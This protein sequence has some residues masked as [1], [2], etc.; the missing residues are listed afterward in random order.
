MIHPRC[1]PRPASVVVIGPY[2]VHNF[3]D[4]LIGAVL[5]SHLNRQCG[6]EILIPGLSESNRRW[7]GTSSESSWVRAF[8]R[9]SH[10]LIG[11]GGI[12]GDS[13]LAPS[14]RYLKRSA[15]AA[16][17]GQ[18]TGR[19][20]CICGVGAG[21]LVRTSSRFLCRLTCAL[22]SRI[23]VRD[24]ESEAFL[25]H[26]LGVPQ[27]KIQVGADLALCWPE[28]L[29]V[30]PSSSDRIGI[31][32]DVEHYVSITPGSP[33]DASIQRVR[34]FCRNRGD[35]MLS[36]SNVSYDTNTA[37]D[38]A[39]LPWKTLFYAELP[40]FLAALSG[41]RAIITSHLHLAIAA[42]AARIPCFSIYVRDK[43]RRFYEQIGHP[44]RAIA[45]TAATPDAVSTLLE[46]AAKARW[47]P[48]DENRRISMAADARR[49]LDMATA[50]IAA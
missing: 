31:Q 3:G 43:T 50:V 48:E 20:A 36:L 49:L 37:L 1:L 26:E 19:P 21:P 18:I 24:K 4:D 29:S 12:L 25:T 32:F 27:D 13:G 41:L 17:L 28:T 14:N 2:I 35:S 45:L 11:G 47:S 8:F 44:E 5:A 39:S 23:G 38:S 46:T 34:L 33:A 30:T 7:L 22:A 15:L 10:L 9:G 16:F 6:A 40:G 42:Y